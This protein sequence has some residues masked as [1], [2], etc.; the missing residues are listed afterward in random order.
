MEAPILKRIYVDTETTGTDPKRHC[1]HQFAAKVVIKG[2]VVDWMDIKFQPHPEAEINE[3][4][5]E[6]CH[7]TS[8]ELNNRAITFEQAYKTIVAFFKRHIDKFNKIDKFHWVGYN[9]RFD[10]DMTR[11]MFLRMGDVYFG[12]WVWVPPLCVMTLAGYLRQ[13]VRHKLPNFQNK[14]LWEYLHPDQVRHYK[15]EQWHDALFDID[16]TMENEKAL[17]QIVMAPAEAAQAK[18]KESKATLDTALAFMHTLM[19][20]PRM[21]KILRDNIDKFLKKEGGE[22]YN[23]TQESKKQEAGTDQGSGQQGSEQ[24]RST[25]ETG[26]SEEASGSEE[27]SHEETGYKD[28]YEKADQDGFNGEEQSGYDREGEEASNQGVLEEQV[29]E[30]QAQQPAEETSSEPPKKKAEFVLKFK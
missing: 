5:L 7:V 13:T 16:R 18:M 23:G 21:P 24:E 29:E 10:A 11:E 22:I 9:A 20:D 17:R 6:H 30:P 12:S 4:A 25:E 2:E 26:S 8:E 14:T 15:D 3:E 1:I 27:D 19:S 28:G